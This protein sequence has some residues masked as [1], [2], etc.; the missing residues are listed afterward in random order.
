MLL[1][2]LWSQIRATHHSFHGKKQKFRPVF[3]QEVGSSSHKSLTLPAMAVS[4]REHVGEIW[5]PRTIQFLSLSASFILERNPYGM[6]DSGVSLM[7]ILEILLFLCLKTRSS[8]VPRL[9]S[10]TVL[11]SQPPEMIPHFPLE[12][13]TICLFGS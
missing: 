11:V 1:H 13:F 4:P 12:L 5:P 2:R 8:S 6:L 7:F 10:T 3:N 9:A